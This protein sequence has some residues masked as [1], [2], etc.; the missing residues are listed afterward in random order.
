MSQTAINHAEE[1]AADAPSLNPQLN[2]DDLAEAFR[3]TGRI[4]IPD[5][6]TEVSARRLFRALEEETPWRLIVNDGRTAHQYGAI[7]VEQRT[8]MALEAWER[9]HT[10][11]QYFYQCYKL[12]EDRRIHPQPDHYLAKAVAFL[13]STEFLAF[14][15]EVT[16]DPSIVWVSATATLYQPLDFLTVHD[17][18][19]DPR[20]VAYVLN[21]TPE[22][23]P[24]WGGALQFYGDDGHIEEGYLP[25]FNGLNLFRVPKRHS[26]AQVTS[27][28]GM[29]YAISGWFERE[30]PPPAASGG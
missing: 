18:G 6:L 4:H 28:G 22:W 8:Q 30:R 23:K 14:G 12:L 20:R 17:D 15:R 19:S 5:I 26:V 1:D 13:T 25:S 24:D 9:A 10:K 7:A 3:R 11:F 27:F 2:T 21:L 16:G 29:R